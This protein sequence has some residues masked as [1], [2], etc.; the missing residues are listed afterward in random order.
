MRAEIARVE[1]RTEG[2]HQVAAQAVK[3]Q[4]VQTEECHQMAAWAD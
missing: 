3:E 4:A 2:R 1:K